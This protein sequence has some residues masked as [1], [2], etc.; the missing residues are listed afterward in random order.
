MII[1]Y[2]SQGALDD[3]KANFESYKVHYV[4]QE[5]SWFEQYFKEKHGLIPYQ[6]EI[7]NFQM[8]M[9]LDQKMN[10]DYNMSDLANIKI[11]YEALKEIPLSVAYDERFWAGLSHTVLWDYI[12]Y[13][14]K[15]EIQSEVDKDIQ[16]SYWRIIAGRRGVFVNCLSRLWWAGYLTYDKQR[17]DPYELTRVLAQRAFPS[18]MVLISSRNFTSK[19]SI[20]H[21]ILQAMLEFER[22]GYEVNRAA[23]E[24][25]LKYLNNI[26]AITILDFLSKEEIYQIS[27]ERLERFIQDGLAKESS[28]E[29][30]KTSI[31]YPMAIEEN[32]LIAEDNLAQTNAEK[33][34]SQSGLLASD[35]NK[36][37]P[38]M[39]KLKKKGPVKRMNSRKIN[40]KR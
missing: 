2:V 8:N 25:V 30:A 10:P 12:W 38:S 22:K 29:E 28:K 34:D 14:R 18:Q 13:R 35:G 4:N 7:P 11:I 23:F 26:S 40:K 17:K 36:K 24:V 31:P 27:K 5:K 6:R 39:I 32:E 33:Y 3:L 15:K 20:F 16:S 1:Q 9:A 21:G 19:K 37:K